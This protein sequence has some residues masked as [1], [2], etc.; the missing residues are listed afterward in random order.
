MTG[1][2]F[3]FLGLAMVVATLCVI[4]VTSMSDSE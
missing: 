3:F 4:K 2:F 1:Y